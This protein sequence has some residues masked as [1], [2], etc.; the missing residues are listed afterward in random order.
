MNSQQT[1][2]VEAHGKA[3]GAEQRTGAALHFAPAVVLLLA[4]FGLCAGAIASSDTWWHL[5]TGRWIAEHHAVPHA[6]PFSFTAVG[7]SWIAHEYLSE[8]L[9]FLLYRAG[10]FTVLELANAAVLTLAFWLAFLRCRREHWMSA[11]LVLLAA[12]AARPG[13]AI[14]PQTV[15]LAFGALTLWILTRY[16]EDRTW[17]R[18]AVLPVVTLVWAQMHA[19]FVLGIALIVAMLLVEALDWISRRGGAGPE[20]WWKLAATAAACTATACVNPNGIVL[21][22]F[23]LDVTRMKANALIGEWQPPALDVP[24]FY[25]LIALVAVTLLALLF[26][27]K[28]YRPGQLLLFVVVVL[29]AFRSGRNI[30]IA[31]ILLAPLAAEHLR[32]PAV[33]LPKAIAALLIVAA[34]FYC[35]GATYAGVRFQ[36]SAERRL[37]PAAAVDY[38]EQH[39]LPPNLLNDYA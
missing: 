22:R 34:G 33:R 19:G 25:P 26:S 38:I 11:A 1:I 7:K 10:G 35:A 37:F 30:P 8:L 20:V 14:R 15:T 28:K 27:A 39:Q 32:A 2:M 29:A 12:W 18:L 24:Q 3:A 6:D 23:P 4:A 36:N 17:H 13:F 9:I 5:A 31:A 16:L 21:L